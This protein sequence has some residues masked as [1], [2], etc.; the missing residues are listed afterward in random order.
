MQFLENIIVHVKQLFQ[1]FTLF[2]LIILLINARK[3]HENKQ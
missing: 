2:Q 3:D 1:Q